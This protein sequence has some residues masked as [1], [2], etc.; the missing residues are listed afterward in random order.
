[1]QSQVS[2]LQNAK[3]CT[4]TLDGWTDCCMHSIYAFMVI[5]PTRATLLLDTLDL[6]AERHTAEKVAGMWICKC[7]TL[8]AHFNYYVSLQNTSWR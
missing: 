3:N 2:T 7:I 8:H 4:L 1:M 5:L 6:T